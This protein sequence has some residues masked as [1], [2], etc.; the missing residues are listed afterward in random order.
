MAE[1][2]PF[3]CP[4]FLG[5]PKARASASKASGCFMGGNAMVCDLNHR[6][7]I[8]EESVGRNV[9]LRESVGSDAGLLLRLNEDFQVRANITW[10]FARTSKWDSL[11][12]LF[13]SEALCRSVPQKNLNECEPLALLFA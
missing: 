4:I 2:S 6:L 12:L 5:H 1:F 8:S 11:K 9:A 3:S 13:Q 10:H 7:A